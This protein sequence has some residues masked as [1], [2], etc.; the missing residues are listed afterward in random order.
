[1]FGHGVEG[2]FGNRLDQGDNRNPACR[3]PNQ[4]KEQS[5]LH[6]CMKALKN[7]V[8]IFPNVKLAGYL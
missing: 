8:L 6:N 1:V 5:E 4:P 3:E 2:G 7:A